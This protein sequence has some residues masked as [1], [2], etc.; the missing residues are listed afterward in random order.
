[1][2]TMNRSFS[3]VL[4]DHICQLESVLRGIF[5]LCVVVFLFLLVSLSVVSSGSATY[6]VIIVDLVSVTVIG[7][8]AAVLL[9]A[10]QRRRKE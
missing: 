2:A 8:I 1:M 9:V 6:V 7:V 5:A 3:Q 4:I 10:C